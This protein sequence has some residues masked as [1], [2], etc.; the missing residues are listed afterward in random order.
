MKQQSLIIEKAAKRLAKHIAEREVKDWPPLCAAI[1]Y[2][3]LRPGCELR[4]K[5]EN[6]KK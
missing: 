1:Y 4:P 6:S 3:P 5:K 2:Q